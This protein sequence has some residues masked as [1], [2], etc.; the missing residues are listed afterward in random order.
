[1]T[2]DERSQQELIEAFKL[3]PLEGEGG[4]YSHLQTSQ[5]GNSI[6]F[7]LTEG[8]FSAWHRLRERESWV[9]LAGD[10]FELHIYD[11]SYSLH[12]LSRGEMNIS[13]TVDPDDWMA[14]RTLGTWSLILCFLAPA[15]SGMELAS[16]DTVRAWI[17][18]DSKIPELVHE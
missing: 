17:A 6:Y 9:L 15:F 10:P 16:R 7:M 11:G 1:M 5:E 3:L 4:Y 13:H 2:L 8:D 12:T 14:A 18:N